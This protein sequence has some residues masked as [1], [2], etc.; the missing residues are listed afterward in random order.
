MPNTNPT[1]VNMG[2][3][4]LRP[5]FTRKTNEKQPDRGWLCPDAHII[6]AYVDGTLGDKKAGFESHLT[7]CERCRQVVGDV[8]IAQRETDLM[9]SPV[10][11]VQQAVRLAPVNR[12]RTRWVWIPAGAVAV[13]AVAI[14]AVI[15]TRPQDTLIPPWSAP[16]AAII[17]KSNPDATPKAPARDVVRKPTATDLL[18]SLISPQAD[19]VVARK[20]LTFNWHPI[21]GARSYEVELLSGVGDPIWKGETDKSVLQLPSDLELKDGKY[22]VWVTADLGDGRLF[23]SAAVPFSVKR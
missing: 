18:P 6:A 13:M 12:P 5:L 1:K 8:V 17:A 11:I 16:N 14:A 4:E 7:K 19:S 23:R 20:L 10:E 15:L 9:T 22:F 21:P 3:E 2:D